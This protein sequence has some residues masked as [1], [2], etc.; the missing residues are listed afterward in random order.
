MKT[1]FNEK[2]TNYLN[3]FFQKKLSFLLLNDKN[4]I[5]FFNDVFQKQFKIINKDELLGKNINHILKVVKQISEHQT[6]DLVI[7][8]QLVKITNQNK[9]YYFDGLMIENK[10]EKYSIFFGNDLTEYL[11]FSSQDLTFYRFI[12][13]ILEIDL[14]YTTTEKKL[15]I[16]LKELESI[17]DITEYGIYTLNVDDLSLELVAYKIFNFEFLEHYKKIPLNSQIEIFDFEDLENSNVI[18]KNLPTLYDVILNMG[19]E[20]IPIVYQNQFIGLFFYKSQTK[21][22]KEFEYFLQSFISILLNIIY[23]KILLDSINIE[24]KKLSEMNDKLVRIL[25]ENLNLQNMIFRYLPRK[26]FQK[27]K[28]AIYQKFKIPNERNLYYF[29]F[30]DIVDFTKFS[31]N[32]DPEFII[33]SLNSYFSHLTDIIYDNEGDIDKFMGDN[34]FAYFSTADDAL[35]AALEMIHFFISH[36]PENFEPLKVKIALHCGEAIHGNLG[37]QFR[38]EFTLIG[39]AVNTT[40]RLQ[41]ACKPNEIIMSEEF[42]QHLRKKDIPLSKKYFLKVKGKSGYLPIYFIQYKFLRNYNPY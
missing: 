17:T 14:S 10:K 41:R 11:T 23:K 15:S 37:N 39:D 42:Y 36:K 25:E 38:T 6:D 20:F 3:E 1:Y 31:E 12:N 28:N 33:S 35:K 30:L 16:I 7:Q 18:K 34:I 5:V 2:I 32:K 22:T 19:F 27:V 26:T 4:E 9:N 40:S 8:N 13:E 29:L 24:F 21:R